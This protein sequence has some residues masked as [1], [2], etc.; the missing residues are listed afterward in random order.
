MEIFDFSFFPFKMFDHLWFS[1]SP[2]VFEKKYFCQ[3]LLVESRV[4]EVR[5][6]TVEVPVPVE[7][8]RQL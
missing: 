1:V 6:R 7:T 3:H 2:H 5:E 4:W 8:E